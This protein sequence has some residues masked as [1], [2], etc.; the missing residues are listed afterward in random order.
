MYTG[1]DGGWWNC[2]GAGAEILLAAGTAV[3]G[4]AAAPAILG[5]TVAGAGTSAGEALG[6]ATGSVSGSFL[7]GYRGSRGLGR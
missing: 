2:L 3:V 6:A 7:G 5:A 4:S 1:R